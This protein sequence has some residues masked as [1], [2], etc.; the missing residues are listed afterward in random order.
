MPSF[1]ETKAL[2]CMENCVPSCDRIRYVINSRTVETDANLF[3]H[4]CMAKSIIGP[5]SL[6]YF[7]FSERLQWTFYSFASGI[8]GTLSIWLGLDFVCFIE[9]LLSVGNWLFNI[10]KKMSKKKKTTGIQ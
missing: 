5:S 7:M 9:W 8:G 1:S 2:D 3:T 4:M 6:Q 10:A